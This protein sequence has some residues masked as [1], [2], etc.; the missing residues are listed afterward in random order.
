MSVVLRVFV[1][2]GVYDARGATERNIAVTGLVAG[3]QLAAP[4]DNSLH[5][6]GSGKVRVR[7]IRDNE[8]G[9][10]KEDA[11]HNN[12]RGKLKLHDAE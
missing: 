12:E 4:L 10:R 3:A 11:K 9:R 5:L 1:A 6:L 8:G 7:L 2:H